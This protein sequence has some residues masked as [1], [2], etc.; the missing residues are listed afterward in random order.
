EHITQTKAARDAGF[1]FVS[2]GT[3]VAVHPFQY[4]NIYPWLARL[5]AA[6]PEL[7]IVSSVVL[8]P[9]AHPVDIAEHVATLDVL[10]GGKVRFGAGL[11]YRPVEFEIFETSLRHRG[12]RFEE[13][14]A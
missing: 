2:V 1:T 5:A 4:F 11:G 3:H 10:S 8:V 7:T 12:R 13:A 6:A 14:L 9:L